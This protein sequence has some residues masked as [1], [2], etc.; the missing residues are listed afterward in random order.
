MNN[1]IFT[2]KALSKL[3]DNGLSEALALD[4]FNSGTVEK[5]ST[6]DGYNSAKNIMATKLV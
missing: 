2:N 3:K 1:T 4:A 6:G 5:W